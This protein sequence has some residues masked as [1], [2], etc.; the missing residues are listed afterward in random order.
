MIL[1]NKLYCLYY[2]RCRS[3]V[4]IAVS[5][6]RNV[7]LPKLARKTVGL[8]GLFSLL[9]IIA[10]VFPGERVYTR[11][12]GVIY[13]SPESAPEAPV[14]IVFGAAVGP[15]GEPSSML[16]DRVDAAVALYKAGKVRRILM[17]GDNSQPEY[18]EVTAMKRHAVEQ[19]APADIVNLD[20][21]GFRTYDSCYRAKA[22][23]GISQAV[24]VTQRYHLPRALYLANS[25]GIEAVGL[26]AGPDRYPHQDYYNFRE[27][28]AAIV[29]WYEINLTHPLP[30]FLGEPVDLESQNE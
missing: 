20:Y 26:T 30:R 4:L 5:F 29:S 27:A 1:V 17:T 15:D 22:I 19:G 14:A 25:M 21:A 18:D 6:P 12:Q 24:L 13:D 8:L 3:R 9:L 28:A 10:I 23:F 2:T 7:V 11:Y 16:A